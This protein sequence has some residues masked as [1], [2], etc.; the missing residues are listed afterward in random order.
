MLLRKQSAFGIILDT[1]LY[2]MYMASLSI[3]AMV[4]C[5]M[6]DRLPQQSRSVAPIQPILSS[7]QAESVVLHAQVAFQHPRPTIGL[8]ADE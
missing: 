1:L 3:L 8:V 6:T 7:T 5:E 2:R 4:C